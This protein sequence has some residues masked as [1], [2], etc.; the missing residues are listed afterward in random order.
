HRQRFVPTV[1]VWI[2]S[3]SSQG[4]DIPWRLPADL[5]RTAST[6]ST[7]P[8]PNGPAH[9]LLDKTTI[10]V[11]SIPLRP[12]ILYE[13]GHYYKKPLTFSFITNWLALPEQPLLVLQIT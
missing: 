13:R 3:L 2:C 4:S 9:A 12:C 11:D 10:V 1:T 7:V 8:P 6:S 5:I